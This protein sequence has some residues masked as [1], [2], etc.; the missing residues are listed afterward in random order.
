VGGGHLSAA[1]ARDLPSL[2]ELRMTDIS[3][4]ALMAAARNVRPYAKPETRLRGYLGKGIRDLD[5]KTDLFSWM[6]QY[7]G[8]ADDD[9]IVRAQPFPKL[10]IPLARLWPRP[11]D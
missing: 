11:R 1:M 2:D 7:T 4:Y 10:D 6:S 5:D 9:Q 8:K 3:I